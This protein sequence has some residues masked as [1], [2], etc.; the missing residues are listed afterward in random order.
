[1]KLSV[2]I[3]NYNVKY[4]LE[5]CLCSVLSAAKNI[6]TEILVIDNHSRDGSIPY[7]KERFERVSFVES[8]KNLGFGAANNIGLSMASGDYILFLNPDTL[9]SED[10]FQECINFFEKNPIAGAIG[11]RMIDG[12]GRFLKESK[13]ALPSPVNSLYKLFGLSSLFPHSKVFSEYHLG[14]LSN[15]TDHEVEVLCGAFMMVRKTILDKTGGFDDDFFMYGEDIDLSYRVIK[16]G[17]KNFYLASAS[18]IH[19]KGESTNRS[20]L[21]YV[22]MFYEA[23]EVFVK[24]HY[25]GAKKGL[26]VFLLQGG[27]RVRALLSTFA[28]FIRKNGLPLLDILIFLGSFWLAKFAWNHTVKPDLVYSRELLWL[29]FSVFTAIYIFVGWLGGLYD[30]YGYKTKNVLYSAAIALVIVLAGYSLLDESY[31]FSRGIIVLG[32]LL[33]FSVV[34]MLRLFLL[35]TGIIK[36]SEEKAKQ[37]AGLVVGNNEEFEDVIK[38]LKK[39]GEAKSV[40]GWLS[41]KGTEENVMGSLNDLKIIQKQ[42]Q[43]RKI[44]FCTSSLG[45][46]PVIE[47]MLSLP[48]GLLYRFYTRYS[49]TI[50]SSHYKNEPGVTATYNKSYRLSDPFFRRQ[51]RLADILISL[52]FLIT[53]PVQ[54]FLV[55]EKPGFIS[56]IF[57]VLLGKKTWVGYSAAS[58]ELPYMRAGVLP[59]GGRLEPKQ[60]NWKYSNRLNEWYA[61]EYSVAI[62]FKRIITLYR[63]LGNR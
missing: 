1:M 16:E 8:S 59:I 58:P 2:I 37:V 56:N 20:S 11:V 53:L 50:I 60:G 44:I 13:R 62:D 41:P 17:Y 28:G 26:F 35:K 4:F 3:V 9:V 63:H 21:N 6:E 55:N 42:T 19:F 46:Q 52:S 22:R 31:R 14:H 36:T 33:G 47:T 38:I 15:N 27:I 29:S 43:A 7:L 18:I 57:S 39:S 45:H 48:P 10:S 23:M 51:K 12:S 24:K 5:H 54:L 32:S 49:Q 25:G 40:I 34:L 30:R 61:R